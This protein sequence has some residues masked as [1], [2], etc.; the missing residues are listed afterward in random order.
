MEMPTGCA[1]RSRSIARYG[2]P[3]YNCGLIFPDLDAFYKHWRRHR[4]QC[5]FPSCKTQ[6][7]S[8]YNFGRHCARKHGSYVHGLLTVEKLACKHSCGKLYPKADVSNLRRHERTCRGDRT[9]RQPQDHAIRADLFN[10]D[11][12]LTTDQSSHCDNSPD[13]LRHFGGSSGGD[14]LQNSPFLDMSFLSES[15]NLHGSNVPARDVGSWGDSQLLAEAIGTLHRV[16]AGGPAA[17]ALRVFKLSLDNLGPFVPMNTLASSDGLYGPREGYLTRQPDMSV[18]PDGDI[19]QR[20]DQDGRETGSPQ[21]QSGSKRPDHDRPVTFPPITPQ[22]EISPEDEEISASTSEM[23]RPSGDHE[24]E[25]SENDDQDDMV[26]FV[27]QVRVLYDCLRASTLTVS[28]I[29]SL[30][31]FGDHTA[32]NRDS[33]SP[34]TSG[35]QLYHPAPSFC[36]WLSKALVT[37]QLHSNV[38]LL[39]LLFVYMFKRKDKHME[40]Q[41]GSERRIII[42]ALRLAD[43]SFATHL[44]TTRNW[45][46]V[47][48]MKETDMFILE[49]IMIPKAFKTLT[50]SAADVLE[51]SDRLFR[52]ALTHDLHPPRRMWVEFSA[53][54]PWGSIRICC[55]EKFSHRRYTSIQR[56]N[57]KDHLEGSIPYQL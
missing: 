25:V 10:G 33:D 5:P 8:K 56:I 9:E 15:H 43:D 21:D 3:D 32:L 42:I 14:T 38:I 36:K 54:I 39:A 1:L 2:C 53:K 49:R 41:P 40:H 51:W 7:D 29:T 28:K 50:I 20:S 45:A 17:N 27:A 24:L 30:I 35:S 22:G 16:L 31:V 4:E 47:A 57:P 46:R 52:F 37:L 48:G 11:T 13:T 23:F 18:N 44:Q 19:V 12:I 34:V 26:K 6:V 55:E